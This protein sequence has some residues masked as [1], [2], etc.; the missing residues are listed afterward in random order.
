LCIIKTPETSLL[1]KIF[2]FRFWTKNG[3]IHL[4]GYLLKLANQKD[5]ILTAM[6]AVYLRASPAT[7]VGFLQ[8][9]DIHTE[10]IK[11]LKHHEK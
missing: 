8:K 5:L 7:D 11:H 6:S 3:T 9:S 1:R 10:E 2:L 4:S